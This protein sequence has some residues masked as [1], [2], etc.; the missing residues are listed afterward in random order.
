MEVYFKSKVSVVHR[1]FKQSFARL[2]SL[3]FPQVPATKLIVSQAIVT[4]TTKHPDDFVRVF[5][6][7][8]WF[9]SI[10][11]FPQKL[12]NVVYRLFN[13]QNVGTRSV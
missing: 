5:F 11:Y 2:T 13:W 9:P 12:K 8:S 4:L 3:S 10:F 1:S 6:S 7:F